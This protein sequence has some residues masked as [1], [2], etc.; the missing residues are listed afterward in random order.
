MLK[1]EKWKIK[2]KDT[3]Y[4]VN[5]YQDFGITESARQEYEV[6]KRVSI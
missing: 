3:F 1:L 4:A 2:L 5:P 6:N